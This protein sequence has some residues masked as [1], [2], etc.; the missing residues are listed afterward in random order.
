MK[1]HREELAERE[2]IIQAVTTLITVVREH[3]LP[4]L[5]TQLAT[6]ERAILDAIESEP[7]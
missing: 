5:A 2:T 4:D 7:L 1:D 3:K 6:I